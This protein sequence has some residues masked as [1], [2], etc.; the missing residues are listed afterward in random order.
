MLGRVFRSGCKYETANRHTHTL[1][2]VKP[3]KQE[4]IRRDE[5]AIVYTC[6]SKYIYIVKY[7]YVKH[8]L[9]MQC[10]KCTK[11]RNCKQQQLPC[12]VALKKCH[13]LQVQ[14]RRDSFP[15]RVRV[16]VRVP[17]DLTGS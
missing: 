14:L 5:S 2:I 16:R 7:M 6:V 11:S 17:V 9:S 4:T 12:W 15:V 3:L 13:C 8:G 10:T 1:C